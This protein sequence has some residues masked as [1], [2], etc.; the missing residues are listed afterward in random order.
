MFRSRR[1]WL[2]TGVS[3]VF[4]ALFLRSTNLG[5]VAAAWRQADPRWLLAAVAVYF[6]SIWLR[7]FR[8]RYILLSRVNLSSWQLFPILAIG[9]TANNL[10]PARAGELVR[11][12]V[13]GERYHVSKMFSLGTVAVERLF[14]GLT[15]LGLLLCMGVAVGL[16]GPLR[17]LAIVM[18]PI[19]VVALAA[20]VGI[21]ISPRRSEHV[22]GRLATLAP[23]R[24]R[25]QAQ[26]LS[27]S[28]IDGLGSLRHPI[29]FAV[30]IVTSVVSWTMEGVVFKCVAQALGVPLPLRFGVMADAAANLAISAPSSQGGIGPYE[31]FAQRTFILASVGSSEAAALALAVHALVILPVTIVGLL[32]L[33]RINVSL[34]QALRGEQAVPL[35]EEPAIVPE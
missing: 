5:R 15:L 27:V 32:S 26:A 9:Y 28:F 14:D 33:W 6:V 10:L 21:L 30:V 3:V 16:K 1:F 35:V 25:G 31:F 2:G 12:Y 20:F 8:Y 18:I 23:A 4:I 22:A 7:A 13:L 29:P 11:A 24:F 17:T 19:F 34:G